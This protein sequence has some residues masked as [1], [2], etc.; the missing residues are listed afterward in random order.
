MIG[1]HA[2]T[3]GFICGAAGAVCVMLILHHLFKEDP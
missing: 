1:I 2:F 3:F